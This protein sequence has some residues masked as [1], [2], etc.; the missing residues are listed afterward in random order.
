[1]CSEVVSLIVAVPFFFDTMYI[2]LLLYYFTIY[3][4]CPN[5]Q[6]Y[7]NERQRLVNEVNGRSHQAQAH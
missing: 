5:Q 7:S 2:T 3:V 6:R 1:M 4:T